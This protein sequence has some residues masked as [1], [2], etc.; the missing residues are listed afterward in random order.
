[1]GETTAAVVMLIVFPIALG[2]MI[3]RAK[4]NAPKR[5][6]MREERD[7]AYQRMLARREARRAKGRRW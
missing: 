6:S 4:A 3:M 7:L 5:P 1:M 2:V